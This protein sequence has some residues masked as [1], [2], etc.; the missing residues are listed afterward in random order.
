VVGH[1]QGEKVPEYIITQLTLW[2]PLG[3]LASL[4]ILLLSDDLSR[5][6]NINPCINVND[7][8]RIF[9]LP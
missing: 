3:Q 8:S 4:S 7:K 2:T 9:W 6:I 1:N 5:N